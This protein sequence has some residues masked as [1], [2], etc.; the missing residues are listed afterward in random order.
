MVARLVNGGACCWPDTRADARHHQL[1]L[2]HLKP[3]NEILMH[4]A[5]TAHALSTNGHLQ[6]GTL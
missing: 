6:V 3:L 4:L 1:T 2:A 5:P